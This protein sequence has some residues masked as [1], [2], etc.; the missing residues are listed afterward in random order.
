MHIGIS[1]TIAITMQQGQD[2]DSIP[3]SPTPTHCNQVINQSMNQWIA[4]SRFTCSQQPQQNAAEVKR[5]LSPRV[6]NQAGRG[7]VRH[8]ISWYP[9]SGRNVTCGYKLIGPLS[10]HGQSLGEIAKTLGY[11]DE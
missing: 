3:I 6:S 2:Q 7:T 5:S 11:R 9:Q 8:E 1:V 10:P 4:L